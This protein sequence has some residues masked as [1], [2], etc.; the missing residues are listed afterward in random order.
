MARQRE[1]QTAM[2]GNGPRVTDTSTA[3]ALVRPPVLF[4][5]GLAAGFVLDRLLALP[6]PIG[7]T[8]E[9]RWVSAGIGGALIVLGIAV[10]AAA[11]RNFSRA[12]TPVER[13]KPTSALVTAGIHGWS[14][15]P[16][17]VGMFL[18]YA[19]IGLVARSAWILL[20]LPP[21]AAIMRY[22]VVAREEVYLERR[23]GDAYRDYRARVRRWL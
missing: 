16:M 1:R 8:G 23:F 10:F 6:F 2:D 21:I 12:A 18:V 22:G 13:T 20:L 19:G 15:N 14:R 3:G 5:G 9:G 11:V 7:R 17:Y 4:L